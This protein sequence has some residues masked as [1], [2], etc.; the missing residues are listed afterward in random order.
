M[1]IDTAQNGV[2]VESNIIGENGFDGINLGGGTV[3]V[4]DNYIA[5]NGQAGIDGEAC[6][7]GSEFLAND[8]EFHMT[9]GHAGLQVCG[10]NNAARFNRFIGNVVG[11]D[12]LGLPGSLDARKQLVRLQRRAGRR[13]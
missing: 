2:V 8:I 11:I 13:P 12:D 6:S 5:G 9:A 1:L 4:S 7:D 10:A 3:S